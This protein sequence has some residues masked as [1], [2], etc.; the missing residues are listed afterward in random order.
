MLKNTR[1][2]VDTA[3]KP[4]AGLSRD[5]QPL[6]DNRVPSPD[7]APWIG[8][9]W[10][11]D[12]TV[13]PGYQVQSSIFD[14]NICIR[15]QLAGNWSAPSRSGPHSHGREALFLGPHTF[16]MPITVTTKADGRLISMGMSLR[17]G[18][19]SAM[20]GVD[21]SRLVDHIHIC[22]DFDLFG[23]EGIDRIAAAGGPEGWMDVMEQLM[24]E[25]LDRFGWNRPDPVSTAFEQLTYIDPQASVTDFARE[26]GLSLR[27]LERIVRRDFGMPP[28]QIL[29]RARALDMASWL[30][31]LADANEAEEIALR[32]FDQSQMTRE[33]TDLFGMSPRRF[34]QQPNPLLA[35]GLGRRQAQRL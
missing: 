23:Y 31:G 25:A 10:A 15:I 12:V 6:N 7:L 11:S 27:Q 16:L 21:T 22:Q 29:R 2:A 26:V 33:F 20:Q 28:K 13:P 30:R 3:F 32:Y 14:D 4:L 8:R 5:G 18:V 34:L 35:L 1:P 9:L 19:M 17:P 24:R